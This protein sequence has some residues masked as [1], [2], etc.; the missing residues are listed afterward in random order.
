LLRLHKLRAIKVQR[1]TLHTDSKMLAEQIEKECITKEPTLKRYLA[2][3]RR[4]ENYFKVFTIEYIERAKNTK[5]DELVKAAAR[6]TPLPADIFLLVV[7]EASIKIVELEP[8]V[9]NLIQGE[10]WHAPIIAYLHH[11]YEPDSIVE[12]TRMQQRARS[13]QIVDNDLYKTS[14]SGHLLRYVSK[15]EGQEI[16]FE[17]QAGTC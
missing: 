1:C 5:A 13:Y 6:N 12:H 11:Y 7:S 8:R 16:L 4:I 10:E 15:A 9:I 14:I 3:V 17:I 2:L